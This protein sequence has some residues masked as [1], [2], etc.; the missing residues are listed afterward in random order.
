MSK[1]DKTHKA[2]EENGNEANP[3]AGGNDPHG[4]QPPPG[5]P[6]ESEVM[7]GISMEEYDQLQRDLETTRSDSRNN[8]DGW[9]RAL[10]DYNNLRR[11]TEQ[12]RDQMKDEVVGKVVTPFLDVLDDLELAIKNRP[13][14][15]SEKAWGEGIELVYRKLLGRLE[16]QGVT[17]M[18]AVGE[19]F[20]P[21]RHEAILQSDSDEFESGQVMEVLKP[22][23]T[24]GERVLR[25]ALVRI[26]A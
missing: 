21:R 6:A 26:A 18:S 20:D 23:Y 25:P 1:K 5:T 24:I 14:D 17:P 7:V 4:N 2:S 8:L 22:G 15:G 13:A 19:P 16:M 3:P 10:A 11:R 12:E 9:Q